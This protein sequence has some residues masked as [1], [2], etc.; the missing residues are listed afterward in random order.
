M[1]FAIEDPTNH[2]VVN[3][4]PTRDSS[5][6][7]KSSSTST[8]THTP[9]FTFT[10]PRNVVHGARGLRRESKT[11]SPRRRMVCCKPGLKAIEV[12]DILV[13]HHFS[14]GVY[15]LISQSTL[16]SDKDQRWQQAQAS[17]QSISQHEVRTQT[18]S[19]RATL[20]NRV[21][22]EYNEPKQY[23]SNIRQ[24]VRFGRNINHTGNTQRIYVFPS[25]HDLDEAVFMDCGPSACSQG[26]AD[27]L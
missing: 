6:H 11:S 22:L 27:K 21:M 9:S 10:A 25:H 7:S 20:E 4:N 5:F 26:A 19:E 23:S 13:N 16:K 2:P 1:S 8:T 3:A 15:E 12:H 18:R 14:H 24:A 17:A